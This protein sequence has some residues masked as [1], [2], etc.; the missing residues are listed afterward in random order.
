MATRVLVVD[1]EILIRKLLQRSLESEGFVVTTV[2]S[3]REALGEV[4]RN[5]YDLIVLDR[6]LPDGDGM[7]ACRRIRERHQTPIIMLTAKRE[8]IDRIQGLETGADDYVVKP[9]DVEELIARVK[10][11]LRRS[12]D[13]AGS[14]RADKIGLGPIVIDPDARDAFV[15][16][17]AVGLTPR[18]F[19]MLEL[20]ARR[21]GR[22]VS[23]DEILENLWDD[24]LPDSDKIVAVY[25]RRLRKKLEAD[26]DNPKHL[27]TVRGFGYKAEG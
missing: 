12:Q 10:A 13:L 7:E 2:G 8:V 21:R 26:P 9:F 19:E 17:K 1:D 3:M 18:E 6:V 4:A 15:E 22:A 5:A 27:L 23:R 20:L 14:D 16:G 24:E 11:Q 25:I